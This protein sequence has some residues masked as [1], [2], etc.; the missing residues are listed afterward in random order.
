[1]SSVLRIEKPCSTKCPF[2]LSV[3]VPFRAHYRG[4]Y[5]EVT[6]KV[7][8]QEQR[9]SYVTLAATE[10]N[11]GGHRVCMKYNEKIFI[12]Q[13]EMEIKVPSVWM[14]FL[15]FQCFVSFV[16]F[17]H[18][19]FLCSGA[20]VHP[21]R[22]CSRVQIA[23]GDFYYSKERSFCQA[24]CGRQNLPRLSAF[25]FQHTSGCPSYGAF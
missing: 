17:F 20:S 6:V 1:M 16:L 3:A 18:S 14:E 4:N 19:G 25:I 21:W 22:V 8:D 9:V 11:Y 23:E 5:R 7:V 10:G 13:I 12:R 24:Q 2:P 15:C